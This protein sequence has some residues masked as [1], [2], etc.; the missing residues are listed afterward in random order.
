[1][2]LKRFLFD[3]FVSGVN[4]VNIR[5]SQ[6]GDSLI[7][8]DKI[9]SPE[10]L[11]LTISFN[12]TFLIEQ[13]IRLIKKNI[14]DRNRCHI[15]IDNSSSREKRKE[16]RELCQRE[17]VPYVSMPFNFMQKVYKHPC[18]AHGLSMNWVYRNVVSKIKPKYFGYLDHDI[19]PIEQFNL[20]ERMG[21]MP[22]FGRVIDRSSEAKNRTKEFWFLWAG[23][24]FFSYE[25]V[26]NKKMNFSPCAVDGVYLDTAGSIYKSIYKD[27]PL[28]DLPFEVAVE[29]RKIEGYGDYDN[30][31]QMIDSAWIHA[32][33]GSGWRKI[34]ENREERLK[35][36]LL[37]Y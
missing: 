34:G 31:V 6:L 12:K 26:R 4:K 28:A 20:S 32:I 18:Y 21:G 10:T 13:Q 19:F 25:F 16:I 17:Q 27:Y 5:L 7:D 23:Y 35:E 15:V 29:E 11:L 37:K 24:C 8:F 1:M 2:S 30:F 9:G 3:S 14:K 36:L 22:F 33:N